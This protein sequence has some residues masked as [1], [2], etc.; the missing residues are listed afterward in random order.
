MGGFILIVRL[1][2]TDSSVVVPVQEKRSLLKG[3]FFY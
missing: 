1:D 2:V 3:M